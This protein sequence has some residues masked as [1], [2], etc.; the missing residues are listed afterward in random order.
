MHT[1]SIAKGV[2][3]R[4]LNSNT[5]QTCCAVFGMLSGAVWC[6]AALSSALAC[7]RHH[8]LAGATLAAL[9]AAQIQ[10]KRIGDVLNRIHVAQPKKRD[11]V[12]RP[13]V[14]PPGVAEARARRAAGERRQTEKDMQVRL[15]AGLCAGVCGVV[16]GRRGLPGQRHSPSHTAPP[17]CLRLLAPGPNPAPAALPPP[18]PSCCPSGGARRRGR[19][20]RGPAQGLSAGGPGLEV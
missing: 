15:P 8:S 5:D 3:N 20:Q 12:A 18:S 11:G 17:A 9:R 10:G 14:I 13:P 7:G 6:C 4:H 16:R 2:A 19:V 1:G